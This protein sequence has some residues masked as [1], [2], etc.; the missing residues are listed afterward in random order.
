LLNPAGGC[1]TDPSQR[2]AIFVAPREREGPWAVL[3]AVLFSIALC[4]VLLIRWFQAPNDR[5][6]TEVMLIIAVLG[7]FA[8]PLNNIAI[9]AVEVL[10]AHRTARYDLY[11][12]VLDRYFGYPSFT[13]C[14]FLQAHRWLFR[15]LQWHYQGLA[16]TITAVYLLYYFWYPAEK[17]IV[18]RAMLFSL[19]GAVPIYYFVPV[20]GP[21]YAFPGFPRFPGPISPHI[22]YLTAVPNGVPSNHMSLALLCAVFL[23]RF[24]YGK[25][26]GILFVV[27]TIAETLGFGEH[28]VIDLLIAV[29]FSWLCWRLAVAAGNLRVPKMASEKEEMDAAHE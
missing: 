14:R 22:I 11:A 19:I 13:L 2:Q 7:P 25:A 28:Y 12:Y 6:R 1:F 26:I 5:R 20:S 9:S 10:N 16:V 4:L 29:P 15:I 3:E 27:M 8:V 18:A 21:Y 17:G 24:R 23:W